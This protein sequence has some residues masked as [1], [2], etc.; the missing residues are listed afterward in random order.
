MLT[1]CEDFWVDIMRMCMME[2]PV[3]NI[4]QPADLSQFIR[5]NYNIT[6]FYC[7]VKLEHINFQLA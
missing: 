6:V 5:I 3:T 4:E 7:K 2:N 1:T